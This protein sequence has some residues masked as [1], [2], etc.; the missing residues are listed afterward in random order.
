MK[1]LLRHFTFR[2]LE[3]LDAVA[4]HG[5]HGRAAEALSITQP[6][7]SIQLKKLSETLGHPLF[8]RIGRQLVLTEVGEKTLHAGREMFAIMEQLDTD[9]G[10]LRELKRGVLRLGIVTTADYFMPQ[11]LR[12][13]CEDY[14]GVEV[15]LEVTN[16][17]RLLSRLNDNLDDLYV[18]GQDPEAPDV[19]H[20]PLARNPLV[21]IGPTDHRLAGQT[22]VSLEE[23]ATE[24]FISR[25]PGSGTRRVLTRLFGHYG[26][27]PQ[28]RMELAS[29]EAIKQAVA[30]GLGLSVLSRHTLIGEENRLAI[31]DVQRFPLERLWHIAHR[32]GRRLNVI[33]EAFLAHCRTFETAKLIGLPD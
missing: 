13:F 29:T 17:D 10:E 16:R 24:S 8:E 33:A 22:K 27:T 21:V 31:L 5:N 1:E 7:V 30:A 14:P 2:Q 6:T 4:R 25:E 32:H 12:P 28:I 9:V 15:R 3:I 11:L 23:L 19:V 20:F 26:L 18:F